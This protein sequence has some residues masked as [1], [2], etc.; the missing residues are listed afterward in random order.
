M[1]VNVALNRRKLN[2]QTLH[3]SEEAWLR[4]IAPDLKKIKSTNIVEDN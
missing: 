1:N 4:R 3:Q 2:I